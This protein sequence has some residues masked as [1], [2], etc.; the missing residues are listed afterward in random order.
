MNTLGSLQIKCDKLYSKNQKLSDKN[1]E[2][3][4]KIQEYKNIIGNR[5]KKAAS[6]QEELAQEKSENTLLKRELQKVS[7]E[8]AYLKAIMNHDSTTVGYSTAK[9]PIG[10]NKYNPNKNNLREKNRK[11][12]WRTAWP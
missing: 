4:H 11:K 8:L 5:D 10:K 9:T 6:L 12:S 1:L 2:Y 7:D 3:R